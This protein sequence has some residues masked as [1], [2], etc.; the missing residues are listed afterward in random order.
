MADEPKSPRKE[1]FTMLEMGGPTNPSPEEL[2]T[3]VVDAL[4][5]DGPVFDPVPPAVLSLVAEL[6]KVVDALDERGQRLA[7][8]HISARLL[9]RTAG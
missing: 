9:K 5:N 6:V 7:R 3:R 1:R 4:I 2:A 8:G